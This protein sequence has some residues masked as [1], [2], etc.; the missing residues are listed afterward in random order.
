MVA[1]SD[2]RRGDRAGGSTGLHD[3]LAE[4]LQDARRRSKQELCVTTLALAGIGLS[5]TA[6]WVCQ[7]RSP[8]GEAGLRVSPQ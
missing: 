4:R 1:A 7:A 2:G 6:R 3:R 8:R 5:E